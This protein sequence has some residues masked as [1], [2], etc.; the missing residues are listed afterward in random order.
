MTPSAGCEGPQ[1]HTWNR[2]RRRLNRSAKGRAVSC[3][4]TVVKCSLRKRA[5]KGGAH[6][7][8]ERGCRCL[9]DLLFAVRERQHSY[10]LPVRPW[11]RSD[12]KKVRRWTLAMPSV[13]LGLLTTHTLIRGVLSMPL[14][15]PCLPGC[16]SARYHPRGWYRGTQRPA[17]T[18]SLA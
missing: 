18:I 13:N 2:Y 9:M 11:A 12:R 3:S 17:K 7:D 5:G 6:I 1:I 8:L 4:P 10:V 14:S 16:L 15:Q